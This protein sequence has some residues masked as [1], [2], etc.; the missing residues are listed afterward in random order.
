MNNRQSSKIKKTVSNFK[1]EKRM[2]KWKFFSCCC[3]FWNF[4]PFSF[5]KRIR[6]KEF[7]NFS[8]QQ[9]FLFLSICFFN[10]A[11]KEYK[12][13]NKM[14]KGKVQKTCWKNENSKSQ[15]SII[16]WFFLKFSLASFVQK[17]DAPVAFACMRNCQTTSFA[18]RGS[19]GEN[20]QPDHRHINSQQKII[21]FPWL[22]VLKFSKKVFT[23][24]KKKVENVKHFLKKFLKFFQEVL[25][26]FNSQ[27][28]L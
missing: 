15:N 2:Q 17:K 12:V 1:K 7:W 27:K 6:K 16:F 5:W 4:F 25:H 21:A 14:K 13:H 19:F 24:V 11:E 26:T 18:G 28:E 8:H 10:S 22:L 23:K 9:K 20:I 3:F